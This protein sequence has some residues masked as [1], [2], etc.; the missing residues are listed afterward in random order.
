LKENCWEQEVQV[1]DLEMSLL[2]DVQEETN[3]QIPNS[4]SSIKHVAESAD[5]GWYQLLGLVA[6]YLLLPITMFLGWF[7]FG[8]GPNHI[9]KWRQKLYHSLVVAGRF[10]NPFVEWE[11]KNTTNVFAYF[12]WQLTRNNRNG[13]PSN[14]VLFFCLQE[15][16]LI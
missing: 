1:E 6:D 9:P 13:N 15:Q 10:V 14:E 16:T 2:E 11:D 7:E 5:L 4:K 12:K 8:S 3:H